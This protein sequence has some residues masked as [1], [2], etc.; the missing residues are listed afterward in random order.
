MY[1]ITKNSFM[2]GVFISMTTD[3]KPNVSNSDVS[4]Q[5]I[6]N[7]T[8]IFQ[9]YVGTI[10]QQKLSLIKKCKLDLNHLKFISSN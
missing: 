10:L 4:Q 6:S 9:T 5:I 8:V 2:E 1:P 7:D 3:S